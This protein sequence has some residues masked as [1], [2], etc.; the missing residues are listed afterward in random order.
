MAKC[1]I[2]TETIRDPLFLSCAHGFCLQ[3]VIGLIRVRTRRCPNCRVRITWT[4]P[5]IK[6]RYGIGN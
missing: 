1:L 6:M 2:C 5:E 4:I 3:C